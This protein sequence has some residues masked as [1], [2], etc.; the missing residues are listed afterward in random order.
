M[1]FCL[2]SHTYHADLFANSQDPVHTTP[3]QR[4]TSQRTSISFSSYPNS[5]A[6]WYPLIQQFWQPHCITTSEVGESRTKTQSQ[7][8]HCSDN[9]RQ[10]EVGSK[11]VAPRT[12]QTQRQVYTNN[13]VGHGDRIR[14]INTGLGSESQQH[15]HGR[16]MGTTREVT[17]YQLPRVTG[18]ISVP[19][20][21]CTHNQAILLRLDNVTAIAF[22]NRMGG[23]RIQRHFAIWQCTFGNGTWRGIY[24]SMQNTSRCP[25]NL[26]ERSTSLSVPTILTSQ[27][28]PGEDQP[29]EGRGCSNS[30]QVWYPSLLQS[31]QDAPILLPNTMDI[32][33]NSQGEPHPHLFR[34][35]IFH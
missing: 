28:L 15:Q 25:V 29:V 27:S 21:L 33:L 8:Q 32:I 2:D 22:L 3:D 14:C 20:D 18:S 7:L 24:S 11:L 16:T 34:R 30:N 17:P 26:M 10:D 6:Q 9:L 19:H 12:L 4:D 31:L 23:G 35:D 1:G 5:W 13:V